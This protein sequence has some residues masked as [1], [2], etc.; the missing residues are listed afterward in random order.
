MQ[1]NGSSNTSYIFRINSQSC[2]YNCGYDYPDPPDDGISQ[3]RRM[4]DMITKSSLAVMLHMH[5][6]DLNFLDSAVFL[7]HRYFA[8]KFAKCH[9]PLSQAP[10]TAESAPRIKI[11]E[12]SNGG[13]K[14]GKKWF[15]APGSI[16]IKSPYMEANWPPMLLLVYAAY[17]VIQLNIPGPWI[18]FTGL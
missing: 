2:G 11:L 18:G 3:I 7:L 8:S 15:R 5:S 6:W 13:G 12:K 10:G 9:V 16:T 14:R 4:C 1:A 17:M